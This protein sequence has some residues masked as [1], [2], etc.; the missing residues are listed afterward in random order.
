MGEAPRDLPFYP[1]A[2]Q[3]GIDLGTLHGRVWEP[4]NDA[5]PFVQT[6][7][8]EADNRAAKF[9]WMRY[10]LRGW[11]S[12]NSEKISLYFLAPLGFIAPI[13]V[14]SIIGQLDIYFD[15]VIAVFIGMILLSLWLPMKILQAAGNVSRN[16]FGKLKDALREVMYRAAYNVTQSVRYQAESDNPNDWAESVQNLWFPKGPKPAPY[17]SD[18]SP[19]QAEEYVQA[20]MLFLGASGARVTQYSQDGGIDVECDN[21]VAQVKHYTSPVSVQPVREIFGVATSLNKRASFFTL[22]GY[23]KDA[24]NFADENEIP[25]F[26]YNP[27]IGQ[28]IPW[29]Y[30]ATQI[31][32]NGI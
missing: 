3:A 16:K 31:L 8:R 24:K 19:S 21:W 5:A 17:A 7:I 32:E 12:Q 28:L 20:W 27:I 14:L 29:N 18:L 30:S 26:Q 9:A 2:V 13:S 11:W 23:T 25:L 10:P 6:I 22:T 1:E 4:W 15:G